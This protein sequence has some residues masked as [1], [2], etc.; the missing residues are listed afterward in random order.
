[1]CTLTHTH[2]STLAS[3][4][5]Y[6]RLLLDL[7]APRR[8]YLFQPP[9]STFSKTMR[10]LDVQFTA[11]TILF[12]CA[13]SAPFYRSVSMAVSP[14]FVVVDAVAAGAF[15]LVLGYHGAH[16]CLARRSRGD[17]SS[18]VLTGSASGTFTSSVSGIFTSSVRDTP[19]TLH[20]AQ[21]GVGTRARFVRIG[22]R[23]R[24]LAARAFH[25]V[26]PHLHALTLPPL[27][28][29]K[30]LYFFRWT[31]AFF[32]GGEQGYERSLFAGLC[33]ALVAMPFAWAP[34]VPAFVHW[35]RVRTQRRQR[36]L[37]RRVM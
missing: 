31:P 5:F 35:W 4:V 3:S 16:W 7:P 17:K 18:G 28:A 1:M 6:R 10:L 15:V 21:P 34:A 11:C 24:R 37:R 30:A 12:S 33:I 14:A 22:I 29:V 25:L 27:L 20:D 2:I 26:V 23:L 36:R 9:P 8:I 13:I 19:P 32:V